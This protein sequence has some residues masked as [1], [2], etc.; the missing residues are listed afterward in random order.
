MKAYPSLKFI[1]L[2]LTNA[3]SYPIFSQDPQLTITSMP[4]VYNNNARLT[5]TGES[6]EH[7]LMASLKYYKNRHNYVQKTL[8]HLFELSRSFRETRV[9]FLEMII[10]LMYIHSKI[11]SVQLVA[12]TCIF[13]LTRQDMYK[14]VPLNVI[15]RI[16]TVIISVMQAYPNTAI[17]KTLKSFKFFFIASKFC[18]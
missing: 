18:I 15:S 8:Y 11:Q 14:C 13:N 7:Q 2:A 9:P 3:N 1:G 5:V 4:N 6:S 12:T 10:E 17:V 16:I